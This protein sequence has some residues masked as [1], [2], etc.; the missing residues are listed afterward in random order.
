MKFDEHNDDDDDDIERG[1]ASNSYL[2][3]LNLRC[4]T[5]LCFDGAAHKRRVLKFARERGS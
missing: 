3:H 1:C 5:V 2:V 4:A